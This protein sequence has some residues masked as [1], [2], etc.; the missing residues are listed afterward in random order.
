MEDHKTWPFC[1]HGFLPL[2]SHVW[3][4]KY[5]IFFFSQDGCVICGSFQ[6]RMFFNSLHW[7]NGSIRDCNQNGCSISHCMV[8]VH[9]FIDLSILYQLIEKCKIRV[10]EKYESSFLII[11]NIAHFDYYSL[12][13]KWTLFS[14]LIIHP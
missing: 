13:N 14:W 8:G 12:F 6:G 5:K 1:F 3:V 7:L 11:V 9:S 2:F 4:E 10:W